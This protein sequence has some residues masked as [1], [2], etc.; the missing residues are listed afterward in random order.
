MIY[1]SNLASDSKH[2][3]VVKNHIRS[4]YYTTLLHFGILRLKI[5]KVQMR[6]LC[7]YNSTKNDSNCIEE[8]NNNIA[9]TQLAFDKSKD[10]CSTLPS[11]EHSNKF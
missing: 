1:T 6:I 5:F 3:R 7:F 8:L 2:H 4:D 9:R 11:Y 10:K